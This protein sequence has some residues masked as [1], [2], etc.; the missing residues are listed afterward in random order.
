[1]ILFDIIC[2]AMMGEKDTYLLDIYAY[3]YMIYIIVIGPCIC[4]II[5]RRIPYRKSMGIR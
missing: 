4:T 3:D 5:A 2:D 1:M